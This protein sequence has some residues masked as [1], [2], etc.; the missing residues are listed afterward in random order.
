DLAHHLLHLRAAL[1]APPQRVAQHGAILFELEV[2]RR[3]AELLRDAV[4][5]ALVPRQLARRGGREPALVAA[6]ALPL[7]QG[8]G[9]GE[10]QGLALQDG[11]MRGDRRGRRLLRAQ[12]AHASWD[13]CPNPSIRA[14]IATPLARD[15]CLV[16]VSTSI[17]STSSRAASTTS[18][19]WQN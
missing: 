7:R 18:A 19:R 6:H 8:L 10:P 17:S 5:P 2:R 12:G 14:L 11:H 13:M 3:A 15:N 9:E 4:E 16:L 1:E